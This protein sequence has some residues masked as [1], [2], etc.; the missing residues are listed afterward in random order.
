TGLRDPDL[1]L[2]RRRGDAEA[3]RQRRVDR[4]QPGR[5][6][7]RDG[8]AQAAGAV[9]ARLD[10]RSRT[11]APNRPNPRHPLVDRER[12]PALLAAPMPGGDAAPTGRLRPT[13]VSEKRRGPVARCRCS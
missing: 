12:V 7:R 1:E 8:A 13:A 4:A 5:T 9:R 2:A 10:A 6:T 3:P 11:P